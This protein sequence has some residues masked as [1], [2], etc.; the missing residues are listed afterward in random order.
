MIGKYL[1]NHGDY[2]TDLSF[3]EITTIKMGGHIEHFVE[4]YNV[5]EL[6]KI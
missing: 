1:K 6:I 4:P 5:E 3:K 2:R